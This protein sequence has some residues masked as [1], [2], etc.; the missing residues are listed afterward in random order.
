VALAHNETEPEIIQVGTPTMN[1]Y[2]TIHL[3]LLLATLLLAAPVATALGQS[4]SQ[5]GLTGSVVSGGG[6]Q[7]RGR[8]ALASA[9]GQVAPGP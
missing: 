8:F 6:V 9:A 7:E 4:G 1:N 5:Y 2:R 3:A